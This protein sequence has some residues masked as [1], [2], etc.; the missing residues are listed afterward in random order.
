MPRVEETLIQYGQPSASPGLEWDWVDAQLTDA[1]TYWTSVGSNGQPHP[2]PVWGIW[3]DELLHLSIG[4]PKLVAAHIG[5]PTTVHLDS[6]TEVVIVEGSV[7]SKTVD[8]G[9]IAVYDAKYTWKYDVDTYGPL[10]S[11]RPHAALAWRTAGWAGRD[12]FIVT[13]RWRWT[14]P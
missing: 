1:G 8:P 11:I 5:S 4:S 14:T 3:E 10:T 9:L 7:E 12:G 13:N 2:R 6:G